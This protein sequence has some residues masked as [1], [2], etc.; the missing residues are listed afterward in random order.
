M[1][2]EFLGIAYRIHRLADETLVE[3]QGL[4]ER[5]RGYADGEIR[6]LKWMCY[7]IY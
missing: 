1:E 6:G 7:E 2:G 3:E 5:D 4:A